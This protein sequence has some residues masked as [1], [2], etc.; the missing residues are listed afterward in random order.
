M[1][2][3]QITGVSL[4]YFWQRVMCHNI[5][6]YCLQL[7]IFSRHTCLDLVKRPS[8]ENK[9][10][11]DHYSIIVFNSIQM[12]IMKHVRCVSAPMEICKQPATCP[13]EV[14]QLS[15]SICH[16]YG[17]S[18]SSVWCIEQPLGKLSLWR[19]LLATVRPDL[20]KYDRGADVCSALKLLGWRCSWS[21][22][23][24]LCDTFHS[25]CAQTVSTVTLPWK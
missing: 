23:P 13:G 24:P 5:V 9:K 1:C 18:C 25:T 14:Q 16:W 2:N 19:K 11:K 3:T 22:C 20:L 21:F 12:K 15:P 6:V 7:I 17:H 10:N 8:K 4:H